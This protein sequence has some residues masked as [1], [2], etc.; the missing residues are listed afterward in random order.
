M[1]VAVRKAIADDA[2]VVLALIQALADYER[3]KGPDAAAKERLRTGLFDGRL[4]MF[5]LLAEVDGEA[6]GYAVAYEMYSTFE[7]LPK[8]F[9]EDIFVV[10]QHRGTGAGYAL[11]RE[12]AAEAR[13]R[14]CCEMEWQ[15]L[16]W[17]Q[18]SIDFYDRL[19]ASRDEEWY[20]YL[21]DEEGMRRL[22]G[23]DSLG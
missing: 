1:S 14:G 2:E 11:F 19:G 6:A 17:N 3:L 13:R 9:L 15:V 18:R 8:M 4:G 10:E 21:L 23:G 20:T 12:V 7:G 5:T 16:T 22:A